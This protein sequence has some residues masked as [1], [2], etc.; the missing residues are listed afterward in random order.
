MKANFLTTSFQYALLS[1]ALLVAFPALSQGFLVNSGANLNSQ[2][3]LKD[4][5]SG[6]IA[7]NGTLDVTGTAILQRGQSTAVTIVNNGTIK[8]GTRTIDTDNNAQIR[9]IELLNN[10]IIDSG[11]DSFRIRSDVSEGMIIINN[12][13]IMTPQTGQVL[14]F[15]DMRS[16]AT[17]VRIT[18]SGLMQAIGNDAFVLGAGVIDIVNS[19]SIIGNQRAINLNENG[20]ISSFNLVNQQG[21]IIS[22]P[23]M[24]HF[25]SVLT[26]R[27]LMEL[28]SPIMGQFQH[29]ALAR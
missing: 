12:K 6:T 13:G 16:G 14:D 11:N 24:M 27:G 1:S 28:P 10:A 18:N 20:E 23:L 26:L 2:Q 4:A 15:T 29:Q 5:E 9:H 3:V 25:A 22:N 19:G 7:E 17:Q 8:A 21:G